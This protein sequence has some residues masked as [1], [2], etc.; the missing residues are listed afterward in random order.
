MIVTINNPEYF[1]LIHKKSGIKY[2]TNNATV[3]SYDDTKFE[4]QGT[5]ATLFNKFKI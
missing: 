4:R 2:N 1:I 3:I 5:Q